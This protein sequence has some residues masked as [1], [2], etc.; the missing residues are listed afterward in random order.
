VC[1]AAKASE[2]RDL[3]EHRNVVQIGHSGDIS[4]NGIVIPDIST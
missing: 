1:S 2:L 4:I 3:H